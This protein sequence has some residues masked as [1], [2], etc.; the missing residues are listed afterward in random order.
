MRGLFCS[1]SCLVMG[2]TLAAPLLLSWSTV[3]RSVRR[4]G[5]GMREGGAW[6]AEAAVKGHVEVALAGVEVQGSFTTKRPD[7]HEFCQGGHDKL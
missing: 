6:G 7:R 2:S 3:S 5:I 1:I 4:G